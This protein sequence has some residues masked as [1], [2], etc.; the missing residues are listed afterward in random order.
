MNQI[1]R[2]I[3]QHKKG[4]KKKHQ[5]IRR[6]IS[7]EDAQ[8]CYDNAISRLLNINH[9]DELTGAGKGMFQLMSDKLK[10][11]RRKAKLGDYVRIG[12]PAP[13]ND[14]GDGFDWVQ[15]TDLKFSSGRRKE[16]CILILRPSPMPGNDVTA[17]F[18]S[19]QSSSTFLLTRD[20]RTVSA[21]YF[22]HNEMPNTDTAGV[23]DAI[24]NVAV[25]AG[26]L[27]GLSDTLW[28]PLTDGLLMDG[29]KLRERKSA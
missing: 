2:S 20:N 19:S 24:R 26:A 17:H 10:P 15:A 23:K 7:V 8:L 13:G 3:P 16:Q 6:F 29:T 1:E 14:A 9:W 4:I 21:E 11:H 25:A 22:G 28:A 12:L 18:F 27:I 5:A